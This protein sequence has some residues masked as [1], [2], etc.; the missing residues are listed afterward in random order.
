VKKT[1][2][3]IILHNNRR[4]YW[5]ITSWQKPLQINPLTPSVAIWHSTTQSWASECPDVKNYKWMLNPV[6]HR[7][8]YYIYI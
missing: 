6:W 7:M 5:P 1:V 8:L 4:P 3:Y 2:A